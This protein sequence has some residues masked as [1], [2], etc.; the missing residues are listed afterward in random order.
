MTAEMT[1]EISTETGLAV[2]VRLPPWRVCARC[3]HAWKSRATRG[4]P[5]CRPCEK[6]LRA[7]AEAAS[8]VLS[9]GVSR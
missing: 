5:R 6:R 9:A 1:T 2:E 8:A 3:G 7:E 4:V